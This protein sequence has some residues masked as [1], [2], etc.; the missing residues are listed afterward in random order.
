MVL[1]DTREMIHELNGNIFKV[2][3]EL[4]REIFPMFNELPFTDIIGKIFYHFYFQIGKSMDHFYL[5]VR[6]MFYD[7][8]AA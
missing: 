2:G 7:T 4:N 6:E 1:L 8:D 3:D 5:D